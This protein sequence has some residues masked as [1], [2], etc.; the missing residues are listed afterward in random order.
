[1][2]AHLNLAPLLAVGEAL[3]Q[4]PRRLAT[5]TDSRRSLSPLGP[6]AATR[7]ESRR[8]DSGRLP[9]RTSGAGR[10]RAGA[11]PRGSPVMSRVSAEAARRRGAFTLVELLVVIA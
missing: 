1:M 10:A 9:T 6:D 3:R 8:T 11:P 7:A 5:D 4:A 2:F